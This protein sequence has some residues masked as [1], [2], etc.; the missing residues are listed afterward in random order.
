MN[1][2]FHGVSVPVLLG[3]AVVLALVIGA[4]A[5]FA[6]SSGSDSPADTQTPTP[7]ATTSATTPSPSETPTT[8]PSTPVPPTATTAPAADVW[9]IDFDRTGGFAGMAQSLSVSSGGQARYEDKRADRVETGTLSATNLGEL[10]TLIDSSGFFSQPPTQSA[11]CADCFNLAI[12][13]TLNGQSYRVEAV[14]I[15]VDAALKPLVDKL[16]SL[17]Q[18]GLGQ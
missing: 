16:T 11:P 18:D 3:G 4:A 14:D 7:T 2:Q 12:A 6:V 8:L 9:S 13:V 17:L 10:R 15:A 5:A 1:S